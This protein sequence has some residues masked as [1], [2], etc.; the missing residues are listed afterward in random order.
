MKLTKLQAALLMTADE[1]GILD[2]ISYYKPAKKLIELGLAEIVGGG[3][4]NCVRRT[5]AGD[6]Y[7][8]TIR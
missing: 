7:A 3:F 5:K 2:C 4:T 6:E 8:E 1:N